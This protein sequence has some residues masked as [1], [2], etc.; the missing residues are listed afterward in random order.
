MPSSE[1]DL[2]QQELRPPEPSRHHFK[3][4]AL[5]ET[6]LQLSRG[7]NKGF[8]RREIA[9]L[10]HEDMQILWPQKHR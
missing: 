6:L 7:G 9:Q 2:A 1:D 4:P 8:C 10:I 3:Q 5:A